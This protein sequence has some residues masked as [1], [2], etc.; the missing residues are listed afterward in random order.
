MAFGGYTGEAIRLWRAGG[1]N[2]D[3]GN[4]GT[5]CPN[6]GEKTIP[7]PIGDAVANDHKIIVAD[8]EAIDRVPYGI[9]GLDKLPR[10]SEELSSGRQELR[11]LA[12]VENKFWKCCGR[13]WCASPFASWGRSPH[14]NA[15]RNRPVVR[16]KPGRLDCVSRCHP[17]YT[18]LTRR[19]GQF[20]RYFRFGESGLPILFPAYP[21]FHG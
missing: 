18:P 3:H 2:E 1:C 17:D 4:G 15:Q 21:R 19:N 5:I 8:P 16:S 6:Q 20:L 11:I 9:S 10:S 12:D 14:P 7:L 13:H